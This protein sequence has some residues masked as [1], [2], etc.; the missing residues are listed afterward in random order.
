MATVRN[1]A[2]QADVSIATVSRVLN[3]TAGVSDDVRKRVLEVAGRLRQGE[4]RRAAA[5]NFVALAYTG[6]CSIGSPFDH[7]LLAGAS[8]AA[9][10]AGL[11]VAVVRLQ[12][13][14]QPGES[15]AQLLE[16]KG[17]R[18]AV[19]RTHAETRQTCVELADAGFPS[20]VV[21]ESF[22]EDPAA[23]RVSSIYADS[24][25][26]SYR[27]VE[28]L[29]SLG[30]RRIAIAISHVPDH[31]HA[32]RLAGYEAALADHGIEPDPRLVHRVWAMRAN[33]AQVLKGAMSI[34]D[35]PTAIFIADP[36]VAVG[37]INEA[38]A[39]GVRIPEDLSIV[40]FDDTDMRENLY[41]KLSAVCQDARQLGY[42]A[43]AALLDRAA[44]PV[45]KVLPTWL[46]LHG[47][48]A[49]PPAR[50]VRVMPDGSRLPDEDDVDVAR[51][52]LA[53]GAA[54]SPAATPQGAAP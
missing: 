39:L 38:H 35:R 14:R 11:D 1:I 33:G 25:Q 10:E 23:A 6:R 20:I 8:A 41:P 50:R 17:I 32:D 40:G 37:A 7:A 28:H 53:A 46:E 43:M 3:N 31:D 15:A 45:R 29:I 22:D 13:D 9:G 49:P 51:A 18:G 19:V 24:R 27:A 30:H 47:T 54:T 48:T 34:R 26:T 42:D 2:K 5:T 52:A 44:A 12:S 21:G 4:V 36:L 16:R